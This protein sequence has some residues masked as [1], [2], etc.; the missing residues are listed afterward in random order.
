MG[1]SGKPPKWGKSQCGNLKSRNKGN[2]KS[3]MPR[4]WE[5]PKMEKLNSVGPPP[6]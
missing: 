3:K 6:K 5:V 2:W 1:D 4:R